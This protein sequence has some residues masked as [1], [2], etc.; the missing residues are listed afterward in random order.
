MIE[1]RG[2]NL[3]WPGAR[4]AER[5]YLSIG[6]Q[7]AQPRIIEHTSPFVKVE[8][9]LVDHDP[10]L[11]R[12]RVGDFAS[13]PHPARVDVEIRDCELSILSGKLIFLGPL[14]FRR[15]TITAPRQ[16]SSRK[17]CRYVAGHT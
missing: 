4:P 13:H 12:E 5:S 8:L 6:L 11:R 7:P 1:L 15:R 14:T 16:M 3:L 10:D 9:A 17:E 2:L